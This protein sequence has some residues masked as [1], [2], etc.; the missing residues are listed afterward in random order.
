MLSSMATDRD[1]EKTPAKCSTV[2]S[3]TPY[4]KWC[5]RERVTTRTA[6]G[7]KISNVITQTQVI[8]VGLYA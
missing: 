8:K 1:E 5:V 7:F 3:L 6:L 4:E 2:T